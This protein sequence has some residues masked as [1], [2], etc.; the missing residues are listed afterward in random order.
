MPDIRV[1]SEKEIGFQ[2]YDD[3]VSGV[4]S[5]AQTVAL[6][7]LSPLYGNLGRL[8]GQRYEYSELEDILLREVDGVERQLLR[9]QNNLLLPTAE[10]L[11]ALEIIDIN[12]KTDEVTVTITVRNQEGNETNIEV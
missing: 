4:R 7:L 6:M 11:S 12:V 2:K 5:L 3:T 1:W 9:E 8:A 10:R